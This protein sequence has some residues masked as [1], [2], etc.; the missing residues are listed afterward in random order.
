MP[1]TCFLKISKQDGSLVRDDLNK[2]S[3][4]VEQHFKIL[5]KV[6]C[7]ALKPF[8]LPQIKVDENI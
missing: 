1:Y 5:L 4:K 8:P 2:V 7:W 6:L 3:V